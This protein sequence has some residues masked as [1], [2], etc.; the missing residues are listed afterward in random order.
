MTAGWSN[1]TCDT[2]RSEF[3]TKAAS[4][5]KTAL[6]RHSPLLET[7]AKKMP[8]DRPVPNGNA[9]PGPGGLFSAVYAGLTRHKIVSNVLGDFKLTIKSK[10]YPFLKAV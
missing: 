10:L 3:Q 4:G 8:K 1:E 5:G 7:N 9:T 6:G 2:G